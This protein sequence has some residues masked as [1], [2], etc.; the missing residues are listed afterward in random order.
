MPKLKLSFENDKGYVL[1][2]VTFEHET[3]AEPQKTTQRPEDFRWTDAVKA[4][5]VLLLRSAAQAKK[6][7]I[8]QSE[9][10]LLQGKRG[11]LAG[12]LNNL[13]SK[14]A[15][16]TFNV[17]G[18]GRDNKPLLFRYI[19]HKNPDFKSGATTTICW[20]HIA[21]NPKLFVIELDQEIVEDPKVLDDIA[22]Q[23]QQQWHSEI[24]ITP[25]V[26]SIESHNKS[27]HQHAVTS[28]IPVMP[29]GLP[30][31][32]P[33]RCDGRT[34]DIANLKNRLIN[35]SDICES[36]TVA[37]H[38]AP[39]VGKTTIASALAYDTDICLEF[40]DGVY[41]CSLGQEPDVRDNLSVWA[42]ALD[43]TVP[44]NHKQP[45]VASRMLAS[46]VGTKRVLL[47]ID[48]VW[49][50]AHAVPFQL[51]TPNC[52][53]LITT[54][55]ASI[56]TAL[57]HNQNNRYELSGLSDTDALELFRQLTPSVVAQYQAYC[58]ELIHR[59]QGLPLGIIV[60]GTLLEQERNRG[61]DIKDFMTE[62]NRLETILKADP[63]ADMLDL[64]GQTTPTVAALLRKSVDRLSE[65]YRNHFAR[66]GICAE[67]P[68]IIELDDMAA[69]WKVKDARPI[70]RVL[71]DHGLL[72]PIGSGEYQLHALMATL[73]RS[74]LV[75][76]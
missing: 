71:I 65:Q 39:G 69:I 3:L 27:D 30:P 18:E 72:K 8:S 76:E 64:A 26:H 6:T 48:D 31:K 61:W 29:T 15:N 25:K 7:Q 41:A 4:L 75:E 21:W 20:D 45:D 22:T 33:L 74:L 60:A 28:K 52:S 17:F 47:I 14:P 73:A 23:I 2:E 56:A 34:T 63:P 11:T 46:V 55:R 62:L 32:R 13:I 49:E 24:D 10:Y 59:L 1:K 38:G 19:I 5:C 37:V 42:N 54:R 16:W 70:A 9:P 44:F 50:T 66:L 35:R 57:T 68:A 12:T 40:Q 51:N 53:V 43:L 58:E 36:T 67:E